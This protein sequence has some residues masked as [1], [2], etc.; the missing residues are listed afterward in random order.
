MALPTPLE[1]LLRPTRVFEEATSPRVAAA[2]VLAVALLHAASVVVAADAFLDVPGTVSVDNPNRPADW[3]CDDTTGVFDDTVGRGCSEPERVERDLGEHAA[4]TVSGYW[5]TALLGVLCGWPMLA[6]LVHLVVAPGRDGYVETL[7]DTAWAVVPLSLVAA[8]RL[9]VVPA[10][11]DGL[12]RPSSLDGAASEALRLTF[13]TE[14]T[15]LLVASV[16]A[17]AW[18]GYVAVGVATRHDDSEREYD[19]TRERVLTTGG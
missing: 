18:S 12:G 10:R 5:P 16:V 8:A 17:A 4:S 7:L 14:S 1:R 2:V 13:G 3:V 9:V 19:T 15:L 11:V 6:W